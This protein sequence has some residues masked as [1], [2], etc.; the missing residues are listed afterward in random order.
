MEIPIRR[1]RF[2]GIVPSRKK[3]WYGVGDGRIVFVYR[4]FLGNQKCIEEKKK[5]D[6]TIVM[7]KI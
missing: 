6:K 4:L 1:V 3:Y 5:M 2:G 7:R